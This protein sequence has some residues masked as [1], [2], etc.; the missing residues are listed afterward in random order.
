MAITNEMLDELIGNAKTQ[1]D[2]FGKGGII[3]TLSQ[4][5]LERMLEAEMTH[6]L[7]YEKHS[8]E[9]HNSGNSRNGKGKK[10]VQTGSG[11]VEI[12]VP[13]DR[14]S[15]FEP[16]LI[17]KRQSRLKEI[18]DLILSLYSYGMTVRDIQEHVH[19]LYGTEVSTDL[20]ST[21]T[22]AVLGEVTEWRNRPLDERYPIVFID[23]FVVKARLDSVVSNRTVY[24]IYGITLEGKK[25]VLGLYLGETEGAKYWLYV[26]T[27]LKNRGL[28]DIFILCADGLKGLP[29]AVEA[30]FP[31]AIFQTCLVHMVRH[32]LNYVPYGD[33]KAVANDL[34]KIY[35]SNTVALAAEAL[36]EFEITWGD[37][38]PAIIKSWRTHWE[39][40]IPF[41]Q[42]P[43][44]IR[45]V[46][47][48]TNIVESLN[49]TLRKAVRNR[50]HFSTEDG[51]MKVL[52]LAIRNVSKKWNMPVREWK[53]ALNHFAIMFA[54]R[55]PEK[56]IA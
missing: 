16:V 32:S 20:I 49:S 12:A 5:L 24:I 8:S 37:K 27:E 29:E 28:E 7:G 21:V 30:T 9:G 4:K 51:I 45:R 17:E 3:K 18:D 54:D 55:F 56:L 39:K 50:G 15:E 22:D 41:L 14:N 13:R 40:I 6:H 33:K 35:Q 34:K 43:K 36:D 52:Y 26:L 25:E 53:Q 19:E 2:V 38:Y 44:E 10:T 11:S 1:E 46:I 23:G 47:Y 31:K 48:T 42:F